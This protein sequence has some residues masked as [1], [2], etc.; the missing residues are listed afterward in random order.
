MNYDKFNYSEIGPNILERFFY[1]GKEIVKPGGLE[2]LLKL[3][4]NPELEKKTDVTDVTDVKECESDIKVGVE[5]T[6]D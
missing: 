3:P 5:E 2:D 1:E 4:M 6:K